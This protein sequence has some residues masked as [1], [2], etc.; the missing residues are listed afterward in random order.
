MNEAMQLG[1]TPLMVSR[2][3]LGTG[4]LGEC[5]EGEALRLLDE[6]WALGIKVFDSARSYGAA[7][8]H[9]GRWMQTRKLHDVVV[10]TKV[11]YGISGVADWTGEAV[12]R[13]ID[14]ALRTLHVSTLGVVFLHSCPGGVAVRGDIIEALV[15]AR[16]AGKVRAL[17]YAGENEAL[18]ISMGHDA[19]D[20]FQLSLSLVDQGSRE[21]RLPW[22]LGQGKGVFAKR[23]LGNAPW[24][25]T[26]TAA[27]TT[28]T[29]P[30]MKTS[31][32][33]ADPTAEDLSPEDEYRRRFATLSL[34]TPADGFASFAL[35]FAAFTPGVHTTLVGTR[36]SQSL[37]EMVAAIDRGPLRDVDTAAVVARWHAVAMGWR[38]VV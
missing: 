9:L 31:M 34:P 3:G 36:R 12:A 7:E 10:S 23:S 33:H 1:R 25:S 18:D 11:G 32:N 5:S 13:G 30:S 17:G 2:L 21:L 29:M 15:A 20:V 16:D 37:R 19:F 27:A 4:R 22:L 35:R 6:A 24:A 14:E 8:A 28:S 38:G 26:T